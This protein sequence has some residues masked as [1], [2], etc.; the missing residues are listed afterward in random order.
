MDGLGVQYESEVIYHNQ[1]V[2]DGIIFTSTDDALQ[3]YP[4]LFI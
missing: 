1:K 4:E 2:E 3:K